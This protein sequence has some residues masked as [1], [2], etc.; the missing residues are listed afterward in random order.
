MLAPIRDQNRSDFD[1]KSLLFRSLKSRFYWY[2]LLRKIKAESECEKKV[3]H[4]AF[5]TQISPQTG[6]GFSCF[7]PLLFLLERPS[8]YARVRSHEAKTTPRR[9]CSGIM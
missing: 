2:L 4:N 1:P 8:K 3:F 9:P 6:P 5:S 7:S